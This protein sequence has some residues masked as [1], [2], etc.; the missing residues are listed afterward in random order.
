MFK[1]MR[2]VEQLRKAFPEGNWKYVG[3][4]Y[5]WANQKTGEIVS[6]VSCQAPVHDMDSTCIT[7]YQLDWPNGPYLTQIIDDRKHCC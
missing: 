3:P 7:R 4:P 2:I 5:Q 6:A 1:R